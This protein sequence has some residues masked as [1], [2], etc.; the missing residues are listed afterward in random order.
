ML[1]IVNEVGE[2]CGKLM[3]DLGADVA[4]VEPPGGASTRQI[5]PFLGD[6]P[7]PERSIHFWQ[8]N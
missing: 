5:G 1:E 7:G 3:A 2:F 4:R 6:D 8:Y